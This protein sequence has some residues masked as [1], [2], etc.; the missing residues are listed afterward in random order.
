MSIHQFKAILNKQYKPVWD[1]Y[2]AK[3]GAKTV[4]LLHVGGFFELYDKENCET[5][6]TDC[7]LLDVNKVCQFTIRRNRVLWDDGKE[8]DTLFCGFPLISIERYERMLVA[9]GWTVVVVEQ[10]TNTKGDVV[11]RAT[12]RVLSPG[13]F[14]EE[15]GPSRQVVGCIL[16]GIGT[17]TQRLLWSVAALDLS[18]GQ[19]SFAEG[20]AIDRFQQFLCVH[21]AS[22]LVIWS[23]GDE[24][25][26]DITE[27]LQGL[28][29]AVH[30]KCLPPECAA[31]DEETLSKFW[32]L[33]TMAE[34][35][36]R[37]PASRRCLAALMGFAEDHVPSALKSLTEPPVQW[38]PTG[39][40]RLGNAA[41]E[42]LGFISHKTTKQNSLL[43]LMNN[44]K[45]AAGTRLLRERLCRPITDVAT[46]NDRLDRIEA[47]A[48]R[49][50]IQTERGLREMVDLSRIW[51][52]LEIGSVNFGNIA[53]LIRSLEIAK[54]LGFAAFPSS[55]GFLQWLKTRWDFDAL[56]I[57]SKSG[58]IIPVSAIPFNKGAYPEMDELFE[59]GKAIRDA[60]LALCERWSNVCTQQVPSIGRNGGRQRGGRRGGK[61]EKD[62][63]FT[64]E[65]LYLDDSS[66]GGFQIKGTKKR[67]SAAL[68]A[69]RDSGDDSAKMEQLTS[70]AR[71]ENTQLIDL[72]NEHKKW[73]DRWAPVWRTGW[74]L[75]I[76]QITETGYDEV[77][78]TEAWCADLDFSWNIASI[79]KQ[80]KWVRPQFTTEDEPQLQVSGLRHPVIERLIKVPYVS[81]SIT[82]GGTESN[83]TNG[84]NGTNGILLYGMNASGKSSLM[85]AI[86][87][88]TLLAQAGCPVPAESFRLRPY[89][90]LFTRILGNDNL[91][92]GLSS[93]AVEMTEFRDI[94]QLADNH[95]LVLGDELCSG[96]ESL[97]ATA[98]V[99]A[100]IESLS[101][102][103]THFM[104]ATHLHELSS[105]LPVNVQAMHLKVEYDAVADR[106]IYDRGLSPG[107]GSSLYGLEVCKALGLP[108]SYLERAMTIRK[109]LSGWTPSHRSRYSPD[110][111]ISS[112]QVCGSVEGLETH[113][114]IPQA[115]GGGHTPGNLV[116]LC[117]AC[118]D[119]HHGGQLNIVKWEENSVA[120]SG[121]SLK[122][123][124]VSVDESGEREAEL[125][126]W[127]KEQKL[128][129]IRVPTIQKM[130]K[131]M[132]GVSV[133]ARF[134]QRQV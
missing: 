105:L 12:T 15:D 123:E 92:A 39:E 3:Y 64:V 30:V 18:T 37:Q 94:L 125:I 57:L 16:E 86:G 84:T 79:A 68:T 85:K 48:K 23:S 111:V 80:W 108:P 95:S 34:W 88:A 70:S 61:V 99:A 6:V 36:S 124:R 74:N 11:G 40:M 29:D 112:C 58:E 41:L 2:V 119:A 98:L 78:K 122:W 75:A 7:N 71:L 129:G 117:S 132:F 53:S 115:S 35:M 90:A 42:Q 96:T 89:T 133:T 45:T 17:T 91:W 50:S 93:F 73:Y 87:L 97:S 1:T 107:P 120:S 33:R 106:L 134:I 9:A 63:N 5:G 14:V 126:V 51:R 60:A 102:R 66:G 28:C 121:R 10:Q 82:L 25:T 127:I 69:L 26:T 31:A 116:C 128:L 62:E 46:L 81:H 76:Q 22:E 47:A 54:M 67:I 56:Q 114:I 100:G 113:H 104:F 13:C 65:Q 72:F 52:K 83:G 101:T 59:E 21:P 4:V 131:Q 19:T 43:D 8:V 27:Q 110:A 20:S 130:A 49:D 44:C 109:Q 103:G 32:N 77:F 118:H 55:T 24:A 38:V